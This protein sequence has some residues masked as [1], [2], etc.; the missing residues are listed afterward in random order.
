MAWNV[1]TV[2]T[3]GTE[4]LASA[5][6][7]N[8]LVL[9]GCVADKTVYATIDAAKA[10]SQVPAEYNAGTTDITILY[11]QNNNLFARAYFGIVDDP[12]DAEVN[13]LYLYGR[14][15]D[16]SDLFVIAV[17]SNS[18]PTHLP[19]DGDPDDSYQ[20]L[21]N[22]KYNVPN[23]AAV[24]ASSASFCTVAEFNDLV[25]RVVT[26][27]IQGSETTG[28][29]QNIR[30]Q[31]AF[32]NRLYTH[33]GFTSNSTSYEVRGKIIRTPDVQTARRIVFAYLATCNVPIDVITEHVVLTPFDAHTNG[34]YAAL[35]P[36]SRST[37]SYLATKGLFMY[38][39]GISNRFDFATAL[40]N[41]GLPENER[42]SF[43]GNGGTQSP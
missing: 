24:T 42:V 18:T 38:I 13:T 40:L 28:E 15:Y 16:S 8:S 19:V 4:L 14:L 36:Q 23:T 26:T 9:V 3:K 25:S 29:D 27:H 39:Q 21:F 11:V 22:F 43:N 2:T 33:D 30:G 1:M 41:A 31:K 5:T 35:N 7:D 32:L 10:V 12:D 6:V 37:R 34:F 20:V 17:A